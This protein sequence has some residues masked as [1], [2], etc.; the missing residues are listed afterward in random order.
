MEPLQYP[1]GPLEGRLRDPGLEALLTH[2]ASAGLPGLCLLS[3][4]ERLAD[5][6]AYEQSDLN[7][8][9]AVLR[10]DLGNLSDRDGAR[11]LYQQGVKRA[12]A[13]AL[14]AED[15]ELQQ[16][17]RAVRGHALTLSLLGSYLALAY[18]GDIRRR[19]AINLV[20][21]DRETKNGHAFKVMHAYATWLEQN[22]RTL[23]NRDRLRGS[24]K[25]GCAAL[26]HPGRRGGGRWRASPLP[27]AATRSNP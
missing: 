16:A 15:E 12:G 13:A 1:P 25:G 18:E 3:S 7:P 19:Q 9:G 22:G 2:L 4:R 21:A 20:E 6:A 26:I 27:Q 8:H 5:L 24:G 11:L 17:S 14:M 23:R 10:L